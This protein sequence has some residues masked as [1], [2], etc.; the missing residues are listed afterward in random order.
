MDQPVFYYDLS[1]PYAYLA[2]C[3]VDNVLPARPE[4]RPIAFGAVNHSLRRNGDR[5]SDGSRHSNLACRSYF[6]SN[7]CHHASNG[8]DASCCQCGYSDS[9]SPGDAGINSW[10]NIYVER[11]EFNVH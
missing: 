10:S 7:I 11:T 8:I 9:R 2:A 1:S 4:W 5:Q 6:S 3:R